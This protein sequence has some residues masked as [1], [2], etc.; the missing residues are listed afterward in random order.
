[1]RPF[2][3]RVD[4][5]GEC[6]CR[7]DGYRPIGT[8]TDVGTTRTT[9]RI[10]ETIDGTVFDRWRGNPDYRP[11][12]LKDWASLKGVDPAMLTGACLAR[13]PSVPVG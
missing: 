3:F 7:L 4:L 1:M 9:E 13:D 8:D 6:W 10:N 12:N 2:G 11:R 5:K